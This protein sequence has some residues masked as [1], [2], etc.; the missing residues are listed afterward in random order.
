MLRWFD[1]NFKWY[2]RVS[3]VYFTVIEVKLCGIKCGSTCPCGIKCCTSCGIK[4]AASGAETQSVVEAVHSSANP[5]LH[6]NPMPSPRP[7]PPQPAV[8]QP[9]TVDQ[10]LDEARAKAPGGV[11]PAWSS[12]HWKCKCWAIAC[13]CMHL[14]G[15][16]CVWWCLVIYQAMSSRWWSSFYSLAIESVSSVLGNP[17]IGG[18]E[19]DLPFSMGWFSGFSR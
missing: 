6:I 18:L 12:S 7:P 10:L 9:L 8:A 4:V 15:P 5:I 3:I 1:G 2:F 13:A 19:D 14:K 16:W 11:P 17:K